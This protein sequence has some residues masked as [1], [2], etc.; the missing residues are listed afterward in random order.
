MKRR[1]FTLVM[2]LFMLSMLPLP[3]YAAFYEEQ[4]ILQYVVDQADILS[5]QE[6][7]ELEAVAK[8]LSESS[9]CDVL[10]AAVT[11]MDGYSAG[12]Y[13][14]ML[15]TGNWWDSDNAVLF[16]LAMEE[17]EWY[18]ATFGDAIY[19][20]TDYGL[21]ML[22]EAA[23]GSFSDGNYY[24]GFAVYLALLPE[25]FEARQDSKPIDNNF[26]DPGYRNEVVYYPPIQ[27][28]SFWSVLPVSLLIGLAA[29]T[30]SLFAMRSAMNTKRR[31]HSAGDY[32]KS[33][34]YHLRTRQDIFLYSNLSKTRRQ[35]NSGG[36]GGHRGG[37]S[38]IHRS[39][40][41]R[42]HGG[43]GGRF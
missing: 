5:D 38:S 41:G 22:G 33:G 28:R 18:I 23:V 39:S 1:V 20:F 16:L 31:Q 35:Q 15:N 30:I 32:L 25:Y 40:G 9:G 34:T 27:R 17:R 7:L 19:T 6:N 42:S 43:R 8:E 13:A 11:D 2:C 4:Q 14:A 37:G 36:P 10:I 12:D 26:Y 21:D 3:S 24:E 29:A